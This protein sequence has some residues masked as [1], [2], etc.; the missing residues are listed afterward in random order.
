MLKFSDFYKYHNMYSYKPP[1][2]EDSCD[3][4]PE[5]AVICSFL[6]RFGDKIDLELD[7]E[8]LKLAIEDQSNL[9]E[10]LINIHVKLLK[11]LRRYFVRDQW[12]KALIRFVSEYSYEHAYEI[13]S[14]GYQKTRP[15]V[16]L[17]LLSRLLDVQFQC[18]Q[19]FKAAVNLCEADDLRVPPLG[20]DIK[21]NTYWK[22][23]DKRGNFKVFREE[24]LDYKSW[25][26]ICSNVIE[27]QLLIDEL[28]N[29]QNEIVKGEPMPEPYIPLPEIFP[30][31]F[32]VPEETPIEL[33]IEEETVSS[34][35]KPSH[36]GRKPPA[37]N[38]LPT[39]KEETSILDKE[40]NSIYNSLGNEAELTDIKPLI[41]SEEHLPGNT[42]AVTLRC[43]H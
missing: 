30:E 38:C 23:D 43:N 34:S 25:K 12:E 4:N 15:S 18:D 27:L 1:G 22:K 17:E 41:K 8:R 28:D 13:E 33:P 35:R 14:V 42:A 5:F 9:D 20:R 36:K 7:I 11:K 3:L 2:P 6:S 40:N 21:G 26:N 39:V 31:Y 24:P 16:K 32:T 29:I 19:K 37:S 10:D